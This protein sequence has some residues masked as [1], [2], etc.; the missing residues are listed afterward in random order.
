MRART[1]FR[2]L[3]MLPLLGLGLALSL[4]L[5][6]CQTLGLLPVAA[7]AGTVEGV[8][9]NQ[10]GKTASDHLVSAITGENCSVLRYTKNGKYC[11]TD[12]EI[13]AEQA[14][15]HRPYEGTCYRV[16]GNVACYDQADATHTSETEV[17][18][19]VP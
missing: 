17:Y 4:S 8:S 9:L 11:L 6:G 15:L 13:A 19:Y 18:Q 10:T 2:R 1:P 16:R 5:G 3:S 12:A 14:R 7:V